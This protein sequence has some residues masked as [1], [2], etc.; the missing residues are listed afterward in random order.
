MSLYNYI[1]GVNAKQMPVPMMNILNGGKHSD[2]NI[3][4]Q[5]FMIVPHGG[6]S[7]K[8]CLQ[9]GVNI[10]NKLKNVLR[11]NGYSVSVGDEGGF[12]PNLPDENIAI[13]YILEAI[14][15]ARICSWKRRIT[16]IRYSKYR[17]A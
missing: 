11:Q 12:A 16:G 9:I 17:N 13:E 6:K 2:N 5:E 7:L 4:I 15:K 8:E 14:G 10:Y 1:G 3:N